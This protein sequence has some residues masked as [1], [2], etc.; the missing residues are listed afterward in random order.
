YTVRPQRA[1]K[2]REGLR[3]AAVVHDGDG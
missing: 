3:G 1:A 2:D